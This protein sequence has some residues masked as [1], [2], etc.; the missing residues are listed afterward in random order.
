M[1]KSVFGANS[2]SNEVQGEFEVSDEGQYGE[3]A[4]I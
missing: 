4:D 1:V 3:V 2:L